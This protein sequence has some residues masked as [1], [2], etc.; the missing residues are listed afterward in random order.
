LEALK[1]V[2]SKT[3]HSLKCTQNLNWEADQ[4]LSFFHVAA[5]GRVKPWFHTWGACSSTHGTS[6]SSMINVS[7]RVRP[8]TQKDLYLWLHSNDKV[9]IAP[10]LRLVCDPERLMLFMLQIPCL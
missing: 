9:C 2:L 10:Y 4:T 6:E 5:L 3:K 1:P 8:A 7:S